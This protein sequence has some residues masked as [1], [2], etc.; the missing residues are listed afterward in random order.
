MS[1]LRS[2]EPAE[3]G[4]FFEFAANRLE[5]GEKILDLIWRAEPTFRKL[6]A[7]AYFDLVDRRRKRWEAEKLRREL[8]SLR[9]D[10]PVGALLSL[11]EEMDGAEEGPLL[12]AGKELFRRVYRQA[13]P[14]DPRFLLI[15]A[16]EL[17]EEEFIEAGRIVVTQG[18]IE[19]CLYALMVAET[20][21]ESCRAGR[22]FFNEGLARFGSE[23][24]ALARGIIYAKGEGFPGGYLRELGS[25]L[26]RALEERPAERELPDVQRA[27]LISGGSRPRLKRSVKRS[28]KR[29]ARVPRNR[30]EEVA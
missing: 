30:A 2:E 8:E 23:P 9:D 22:I 7:Q 5:E 27:L 14:H 18:T 3:R 12:A 16:E 6:V 21:S 15:A 25:A 28:G 4:W 20:R 19:S 11:L 1:W 24:T 29:R 17:E 26:A 10:G 13:L